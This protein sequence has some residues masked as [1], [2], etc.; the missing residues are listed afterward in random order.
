MIKDFDSIPSLI[1]IVMN[2]YI[3]ELKNYN[4]SNIDEE[5]HCL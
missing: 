2:T 3:K 5:K 4:K 1:E